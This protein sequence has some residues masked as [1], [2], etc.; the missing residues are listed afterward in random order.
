MRLN[1][2]IDSLSAQSVSWPWGEAIL[3]FH[4]QQ[5]CFCVAGGAVQVELLWGICL[6]QAQLCVP[7]TQ[8]GITKGWAEWDQTP[9]HSANGVLMVEVQSG[10]LKD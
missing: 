9:V 8:T 10:E 2:A 4:N 7:C 6:S 5:A 3:A 1:A